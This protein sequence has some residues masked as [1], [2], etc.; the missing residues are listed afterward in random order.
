[1]KDKTTIGITDAF[2]E[3]IAALVEEVVLEGKPFEEQKKW[4]RKYS[5]VEGMDFATLE[6]NLTEFF[7]TVE[8]LKSKESKAI[9]R[10]A[11][12]LA[13]NCYL[14]E[15]EV[16]KLVLA[17]NEV[18]EGVGQRTGDEAGCETQE[19][20]VNEAAKQGF[21][22]GH[23]YVGL[24]LPSGTLWADIFNEMPGGHLLKEKTLDKTT[25]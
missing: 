13:K 19:E 16:D 3:F 25:V 2:R 4:L 15:N 1:M 22:N 12:M 6:N 7:E 23:E 14:E 17:V 9:E 20:T 8:E 10:F 11:K 24:N 21:V 18:R 5:A